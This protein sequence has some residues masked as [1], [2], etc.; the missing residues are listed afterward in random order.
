MATPAPPS[1]PAD[2][3]YG[4]ALERIR[5]FML[6]IAALGIVVCLVRFRWP[7]TAGFLIGATISYVNHLWLTRVVDAVGERITTGKSRER[8]R[9]IV[10]RVVL[11]YGF[12][13][14]G[15]YV[16]FNVSLAALG[17]FLGGICLPIM[18]IGCEVTVEL[19]TTLRREF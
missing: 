13:A 5:K 14:I 12:I 9:A 10:F 16:I 2:R 18:A 3:F 4:D 7:V 1:S 17:G 19:V 6:V 8:G 15:A 11:R